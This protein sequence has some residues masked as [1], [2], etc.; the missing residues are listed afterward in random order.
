MVVFHSATV[1][2]QTISVRKAHTWT[3]CSALNRTQCCLKKV[4]DAKVFYSLYCSLHVNAHSCYPPCGHNFLRFQLLSAAQKRGNVSRYSIWQNIISI[5]ASVGHNG[6][7]HQAP[8][9]PEGHSVLSALCHLSGLHKGLKQKR[10][11]HLVCS[12]LKGSRCFGS[13]N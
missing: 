3:I 2:R 9:F 4:S 11:H 5:K 10:G 1:D 7:S 13:Y 6:V 12:Q 8:F